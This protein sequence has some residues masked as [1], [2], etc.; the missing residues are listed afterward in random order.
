MGGFVLHDPYPT[1]SNKFAAEPY[2]PPW[3]LH[4]VLTP[5]GVRFLMEHE[6]S[7]IPDLAVDDIR[8]RSKA[9]LF[10]KA[11]LV[12][13]V[14]W[15]LVACINRGVQGL[16]L[17]LLEISTIAHALCSLLTYAVWWRKPKDVSHQTVIA[18]P[19]DGQIGAWMSM[20]SS[21]SQYLLGGILKIS[22]RSEM[23]HVDIVQIVQPSRSSHDDEP[24][25]RR[26][27]PRN[28]SIQP[29]D[30]PHF[31]F[32]P[33]GNLQKRPQRDCLWNL[34]NTWRMSLIFGA[35]ATV[36]WYVHWMPTHKAEG[37]R[38][39]VPGDVRG[40]ESIPEKGKDDPET[41]DSS[42]DISIPGPSEFTPMD[43]RRWALAYEAQRRYSLSAH[44]SRVRYVV[45]I[46]SLQAFTDTHQYTFGGICRTALLAAALGAVYGL[47]H[48]IALTVTFPTAIEGTLWRVATVVVAALGL[49]L[50]TIT[51]VL[52][53]IAELFD[54][55]IKCVTGNRQPTSD[56]IDRLLKRARMLFE[57]AVV[58]LGAIVY[59]SSSAYLVAETIRQL[60]ALPP[61][62]FVLPSWANYWPHFA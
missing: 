37:D 55:S 20:A 24:K 48:L 58:V 61:E 12:C 50:G 26:P 28:K 2:L 32:R 8:D 36:P 45:P 15:F 57:R 47:P 34:V 39:A 49:T 29:P 19:N 53:G 5:D 31:S 52:F 54:R 27:G 13:Q 25:A 40:G 4:G 1:K 41:V 43:L 7:S 9:S 14:L 17:S 18:L 21:A 16:P 23:E 30:N 51:V 38:T 6:P 3:Q 22:N 10:T 60:F 11:L 62:V 59:V 35:T 44:I 56:K 46:A 33:A 42:R